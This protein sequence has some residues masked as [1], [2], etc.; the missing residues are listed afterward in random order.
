MGRS[1]SQS[2]VI[3]WPV[4]VHANAYLN[5]RPLALAWQSPA[6]PNTIGRWERLNGSH[7]ARLHPTDRALVGAEG[8]LRAEAAA[9]SAIARGSQHSTIA[10]ISHRI[11][12]SVVPPSNWATYIMGA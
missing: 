8:H 4:G 9:V 12:C 3:E 2:T 5:K 10:S 7:V 6:S 1:P 11:A